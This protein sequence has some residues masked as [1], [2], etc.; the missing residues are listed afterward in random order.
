MIQLFRLASHLTALLVLS[1]FSQR[2]WRNLRFLRRAGEFKS[3]PDHP[4]RVSVLV[5]ARNEARTIRACIDSLAAQHF[6]DPEIIALDDQ[7]TDETGA[8][9]DHLKAHHPNLTVLHGS[10]NP[11][12]GWNGKS[13]AC[14]RLAAMP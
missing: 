7:S 1:G 12:F 8:I 5:P 4:P 13:Y 2:L 6:P 3:L 14:H 10:E 9:L 11:P